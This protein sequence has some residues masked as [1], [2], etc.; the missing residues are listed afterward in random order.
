M[1]DLLA[2]DNNKICNKYISRYFDDNAISY[3]W[4]KLKASIFKSASCYLNPP[5]RNDYLELAIEEI[6]NKKI[7][8]YVILP[9]WPSSPMVFQSYAIF[10]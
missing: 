1:L 2:D 3:N 8:S 10:D 6:I 9:I 5:F 4:M 7:K